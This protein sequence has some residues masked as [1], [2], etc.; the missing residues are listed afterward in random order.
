MLDIFIRSGKLLLHYKPKDYKSKLFI[1]YI[2]GYGQKM[3]FHFIDGHI[4]SSQDESTG[5][6]VMTVC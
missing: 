6:T 5:F 2:F 1:N 4:S 3:L